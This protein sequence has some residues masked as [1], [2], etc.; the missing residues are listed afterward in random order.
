MKVLSNLFET[1][2]LSRRETACSRPH[3][4]HR[5]RRQRSALSCETLEPK[6]L[7]AADVAVQFSDQVLD[8]TDPVNVAIEGKF[9]DTAVSGTV[10]K[11]ETNAPL[12]DNDF[13]V[14]LTDNT[15]LTNANFLSYVNNS[16][17]DG[18]M[19]HRSV[20]NFVLQGLFAA[21]A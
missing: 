20:S 9:G 14:E 16:G 1:L 5:I 13:Y 18:T 3:R 10:V 6:R 12:A 19:I 17:Y 2:R 15:P 8:T 7:L 21:R 4:R 11:F